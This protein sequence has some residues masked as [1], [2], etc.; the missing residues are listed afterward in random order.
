LLEIVRD[1]KTKKF[2]D[3]RVGRKTKIMK[4]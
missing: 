3:I 2:K 4:I 1:I